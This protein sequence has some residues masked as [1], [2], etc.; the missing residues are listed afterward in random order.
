[1]K[2]LCGAVL[3]FF[4][5]TVPVYADIPSY[6][7]SSSTITRIAFCE[8]SGRQFNQDGSVVTHINKDGS[9][10]RGEF[11]INERW[12]PMA[13]KM[14]MDINTIEGN[15]AFALWLIDQQGYQ[16]WKFSQSCWG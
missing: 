16:P 9:K 13:Q 8:S 3:A 11:Q 12:L 14:G 7:V 5:T 2:Y 10:D 1:M 6:L 15:T 4:L